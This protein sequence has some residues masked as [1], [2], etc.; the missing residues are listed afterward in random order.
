MDEGLLAIRI[1][2]PGDRVRVEIDNPL[3]ATPAVR[4]RQPD[5]PVQRAGA[6]DAAVRYGGRVEDRGRRAIGSGCTSNSHTVKRDDAEMSDATSI[7]IVDDEPPARARLRECWL[8][9]R[10][11]FPTGSSV[12]PPMRPRR[13]RRS[14][15]AAADRA[16]RHPDAGH[17][18]HRARAPHLGAGTVEGDRTIPS[19]MPRSSSSP[20]STTRGRGL[21]GQRDR[22]PP[23]AGPR[24]SACWTALRRA[25]PSCR[26]STRTSYDR[27]PGPQHAPTRLSVHE[28]GPVIRAA[29]QG[30]R[31]QGRVKYIMV[32]E[33]CAQ[34]DQELMILLEDESNDRFLTTATPWR[35]PPSPGSTAGRPWLRRGAVLTPGGRAAGD[36]RHSPATLDL[37]DEGGELTATRAALA[38]TRPRHSLHRLRIATCASRLALGRA[39]MSWI[40]L[41]VAPPQRW[42]C[43]LAPRRG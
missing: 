13:S 2:K 16:A 7:L 41:K 14:N 37:L 29:E 18:R 10:R 33:E 6:P 34:S 28:R 25:R 5:G 31:P 42:L 15:R 17:D 43:G 21:R 19:P 35:A 39:T 12:R 1:T 24:A 27:S 26:R 11:S 20:P 38:A 30:R 4:I 3:S 22:L 36:R 23:Q 32:H 8:T 9:W 40:F